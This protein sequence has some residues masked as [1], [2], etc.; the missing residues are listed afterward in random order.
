MGSRSPDQHA[1]RPE[2]ASHDARKTTRND[3]TASPYRQDRAAPGNTTLQI[4]WDKSMEGIGGAGLPHRNTA[5]LMI[6]WADELDDLKTTKEVDDLATVFEDKFRYKVVK[7]RLEAGKRPQIQV[8]QY[9]ANFVYDHDSNNTLLIVY[10]AG[11]GVHP[12]KPGQLTLA[13]TR[14]PKEQITKRNSVVWHEAEPIIKT[15]DADVLFIFDCCFAGNMAKVEDRAYSERKFEFLA[16]CASTSVT[17]M[18]GKRSFTSALIWA[19]ERLAETRPQFTT[20]ELQNK[21]NH[22]SPDFPEDQTV[23][24]MERG[25]PCLQKLVLAPLPKPGEENKTTYAPENKKASRIQLYLDLRFFY[26]HTPDEDEILRLSAG[27]RELIRTESISPRH[28]SWAGLKTADMVRNVAQKWRRLTIKDKQNPF[29]QSPQSPSGPLNNW[30]QQA[31]PTN[32]PTP[33]ESDAGT[34]DT[35]ESSPRNGTTNVAMEN[36]SIDAHVDNLTIHRAVA[37]EASGSDYRV[38]IFIVGLVSMLLE[39]FRRLRPAEAPA[40]VLLFFCAYAWYMTALHERNTAAAG[41]TWTSRYFSLIIAGI[42]VFICSHVL[43]AEGGVLR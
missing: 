2:I 18:P 22:E 34:V 28:V 30:T 43:L 12:G 4:A 32:L 29:F 35:P 15:A 14:S 24:L 6:S 38:A 39:C 36:V 3:R 26:D 10:Y 13:G 9:L 31:T 33:P 41:R 37:G 20:M 27:L 25:D 21:I 11:H 1:S 7:K 5:V 40:M 8:Q 19:L 23:Q 16:A 17:P 42:S